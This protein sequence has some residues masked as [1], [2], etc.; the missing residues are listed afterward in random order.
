M[1]F[2]ETKEEK[3]TATA[4]GIAG[5]VAA[6]FAV[7]VGY[8]YYTEVR[9]LKSSADWLPLPFER[10]CFPLMLAR[11]LAVISSITSRPRDLKTCTVCRAA[12]G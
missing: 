1:A 3:Q 12:W 11:L 2:P 4:L 7:W 5:G 8:T 9:S 6:F 10:G